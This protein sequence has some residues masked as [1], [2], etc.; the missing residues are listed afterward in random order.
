[1]E[2]FQWLIGL[3]VTFNVWLLVAG[4]GY[5]PL[6]LLCRGVCGVLIAS[7]LHRLAAPPPSRTHRKPH[8][9][10]ASNAAF[11]MRD[12]CSEEDLAAVLKSCS[13]V[14]SWANPFHTLLVVSGL[15]ASLIAVH[16][17][18]AGSLLLCA[19]GVG[20]AAA[21]DPGF[22]AQA[23]ARG[24]G[25]L[26]FA[27]EPHSSPDRSRANPREGPLPTPGVTDP[28][29]PNSNLPGPTETVLTSSH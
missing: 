19:L 4:L 10:D 26:R 25:V 12:L 1:M 9:R 29:A 14:L 7:G 5:S 18:P 8:R 16:F 28:A 13:S 2:R 6:P 27:K 17:A 21:L 24:T 3:V 20:G 23:L 22:V 11:A 15:A